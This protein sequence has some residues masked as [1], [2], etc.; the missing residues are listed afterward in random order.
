MT[1]PPL[2]LPRPCQMRTLIEFFMNWTWPSAISVFTPR[3]VPSKPGGSFLRRP[4]HLLWHAASIAVSSHSFACRSA[5]GS[6][7]LGPGILSLPLVLG[8]SGVLKSV[9]ARGSIL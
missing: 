7:P 3:S 6:K 2:R 1:S 9:A 5:S 8:G 4:R